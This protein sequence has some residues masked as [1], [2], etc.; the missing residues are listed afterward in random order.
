MQGYEITAHE[1][2]PG[3]RHALVINRVFEGG[4]HLAA[5]E[6]A[7]RDHPLAQWAYEVN[8]L[9]D[10]RH[11]DKDAPFLVSFPHNASCLR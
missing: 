11:E 3:H 5:P 9:A 10:L 1:C 7:Y 4:L 6:G 8:R 2:V